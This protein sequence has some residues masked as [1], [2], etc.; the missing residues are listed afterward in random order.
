MFLFHVRRFVQYSNSYN[1]F[2]VTQLLR[3][4]LKYVLLLQSYI[5][6]FSVYIL[7][8]LI[9]V[10]YTVCR[11]SR[12]NNT[13]FHTLMIFVVYFAIFTGFQSCDRVSRCA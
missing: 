10:M 9:A 5:E 12:T 1:F 3:H 7:F 4:Y 6:K 13:N 2:K 11:I 8:I